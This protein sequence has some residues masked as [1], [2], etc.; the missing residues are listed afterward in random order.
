MEPSPDLSGISFSLEWELLLHFL[1]FGDTGGVTAP[2]GHAAG[3]G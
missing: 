2:L 3:Q 1:V